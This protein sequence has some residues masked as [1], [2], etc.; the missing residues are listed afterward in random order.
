MK[1]FNIKKGTRIEAK[2]MIMVVTGE[3]EK[4]FLGYYEYKGNPV[5][6]CSILKDMFSNPHFM[7][8]ITIISE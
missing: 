5:G 1:N 7:N 4:A 3:N 6:Q 2:K 8:G